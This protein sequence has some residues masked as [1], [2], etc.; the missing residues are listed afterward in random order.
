MLIAI[1]NLLNCQK[2]GG[3]IPSLVMGKRDRGKNNPSF[4]GLRLHIHMQNQY[5]CF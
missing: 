5:F 1:S 2:V 4:R 3:V